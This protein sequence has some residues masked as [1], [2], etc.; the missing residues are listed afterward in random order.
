MLQLHARAIHRM[1]DTNEAQ[2]GHNVRNTCRYCAFDGDVRS[3]AADLHLNEDLVEVMR[4]Y[5]HDCIRWSRNYSAA[6]GWIMNGAAPFY[7][8]SLT[9]AFIKSAPDNSLQT[10]NVISMS[11]SNFTIEVAVTFSPGSQPSPRAVVTSK[12]FT[13]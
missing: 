1:F 8:A 7:P 10:P 9:P 5:I 2:L 13:T 4:S 6:A 12:D 3:H 11:L